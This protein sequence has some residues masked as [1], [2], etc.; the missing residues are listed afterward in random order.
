M[1][2][3]RKNFNTDAILKKVYPLIDKALSSRMA[4]WKLCMSRFM[5]KR[6]TSLFDTMPC[7]RIVFNDNDRKDLFESLGI[8]IVEVTEGMKE[9]YYWGMDPFK[10]SQAKDPLSIVALCIVRYFLLK[11]DEKNLDLSLVY[12]AFS[13]KYYP[14]VHAGS[15]PLVAPSKYRHVMEYVVNNRL[16]QKFELKSQ[17]TVIGA[18]RNISKTWVEAYFDMMKRFE[19]EDITYVIQQIHNRI[20]S[21]M[22]N[23][24]TLYYESYEI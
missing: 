9:T 16:N 24:A 5:Q 11:K 10:P 1:A 2:I 6:S 13:G 21:F 3:K 22:K 19:D 18:I 8:S 14:S 7:D 20:K 15:F 4:Q 23:I 17:G 12:Q